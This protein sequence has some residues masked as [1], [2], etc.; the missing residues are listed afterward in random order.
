[1]RGREGRR[2]AAVSRHFTSRLELQS[3]AAEMRAN[4]RAISRE[5]KTSAA[6][7]PANQEAEF[8]HQIDEQEEDDCG[9]S[10]RSSS[11]ELEKYSRQKRDL[12]K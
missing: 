7:P 6:A 4:Y 12:I 11:Q 3:P 5:G 10:L 2:L 1:M 9:S 8:S